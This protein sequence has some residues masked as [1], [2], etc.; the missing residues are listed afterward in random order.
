ML[1][2][3]EEA[4]DQR[5]RDIQAAHKALLDAQVETPKVEPGTTKYSEDD[6]ELKYTFLYPTPTS[7][8]ERFTL[9]E[10][11]SVFNATRKHTYLDEAGV[12]SNELL[13]AI[14]VAEGNKYPNNFGILRKSVVGFDL[15]ARWCAATVARNGPR[16]LRD[17]EVPEGFSGNIRDNKEV[18]DKFITYLGGK[19]APR[20]ADNDPT[21]LNKNWINNVKKSYDKF[22]ND[23]YMVVQGESTNNGTDS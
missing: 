15:Q 9:D 14:A 2:S 23:I 8:V 13:F 18:M 1:Q 16:F 20:G 21:D 12:L 5:E 17:V 6:Q 10:I 19:Y 7:V 4:L 3:R 22:T 11:R